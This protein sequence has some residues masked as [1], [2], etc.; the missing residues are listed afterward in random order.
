V[1]ASV[2]IPATG[3]GTLAVISVQDAPSTTAGQRFLTLQGST[4]SPFITI[5]YDFASGSVLQ[6]IYQFDNGASIPSCTSAGGTGATCVGVTF[7]LQ[8]RSVTFA[9]TALRN[10]NGTTTPSATLNGTVTWQSLATTTPSNTTTTNTTTTTTTPTTTPL[11]A[12]N[13]N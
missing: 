8:A 4:A 10:V 7:S 9:N 1:V 3:L 12:P 5:I 6:V 2:A 13:L 11:V